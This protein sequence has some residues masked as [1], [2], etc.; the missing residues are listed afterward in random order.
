[1]VTVGKCPPHALREQVKVF[2]AV[3]TEIAEFV[4]FQDVG[5]QRQ[6]EPPGRGRRHRDYLIAAIV[7]DHRLAPDRLVFSEIIV[8]DQA[9]AALHLRDDQ[10][11]GRTGVE[12]RRPVLYDPAQDTGEIRIAPGI[13]FLHRLAVRQEQFP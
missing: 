12:T 10:I 11:R 8:R 1:M 4:T 9:A 7:E 5:D 2:A 6:G 3:P 13:A